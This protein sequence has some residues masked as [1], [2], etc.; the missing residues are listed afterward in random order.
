MIACSLGKTAKET[1][2]SET[3]YCIK[4]EPQEEIYDEKENKQS[5]HESRPRR[6]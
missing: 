4:R 6:E 2:N 1:T 5:A 3:N